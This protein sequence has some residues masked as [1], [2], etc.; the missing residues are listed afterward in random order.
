[1][2]TLAIREE[3]NMVARVTLHNMRQDRDE[4]GRAFGARLRGQ[5]GVCKKCPSCEAEVD[6]TEVVIKDVL[7]RGLEDSEIQMD[8]LGDKNQ[9]MTL[10]QVFGFVETKE[11]GRDRHPACCYPWRWTQSLEAP[12]GSRGKL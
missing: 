2:K 5:A 6:Y 8:L 9:D 7:C 4:P 12:T 1:M 3:N 11:V 10:E